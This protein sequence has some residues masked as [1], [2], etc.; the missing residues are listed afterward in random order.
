MSRCFP[1][2]P[3]VKAA[4]NREALL[5]PIKLPRELEKKAKT[6][7]KKD[8]KERK[9]KKLLDEDRKA[10][11]G[12]YLA[13][14]PTTW[15]MD[16]ITR[17]PGEVE[18]N[19]LEKSDIT[20]EHE[21]PMCHLSDGTQSGTKRK[22]GTII[23]FKSLSN[24]TDPVSPHVSCSQSSGKADLKVT[25][26]VH[27]SIPETILESEK[28]TS[29]SDQKKSACEDHAEGLL[30]RSLIDNWVQ[31]LLQSVLNDYGDE[32]WLFENKQDSCHGS[33]R[34][35]ASNEVVSCCTSQTLWPQAMWL[36]E[37][38]LSALPFSVPF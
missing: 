12:D 1:Y 9:E 14:C 30:Y 37:P 29:T 38:G 32:D 34:F 13:T 17:C 20:E 27:A 6:H 21:L 19:Q 33:K 15:G 16:A 22:S 23:R 3:S 5:E 11:K 31:P 7:R 25:E 28:G 2:T 35:K 36:S 24:W 10:Q 8:K 18:S 4:Q 26:I